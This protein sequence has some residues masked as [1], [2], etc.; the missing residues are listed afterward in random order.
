MTAPKHTPRGAKVRKSCECC[1]GSFEAR[2]ADHK[3][4]WARY[5]GKSCKARHQ[6]KQAPTDPQDPT[7]PYSDEAFP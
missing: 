5:C 2:L 1:G 4:G 3:R 6:A 7:H